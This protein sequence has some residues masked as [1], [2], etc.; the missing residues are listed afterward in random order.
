MAP[1]SALRLPLPEG[2]WAARQSASAQGSSSLHTPCQIGSPERSREPPGQDPARVGAGANEAGLP[3][4]PG[5]SPP[6]A[7][8]PRRGA[9]APQGPTRGFAPPG[10]GRYRAGPNQHAAVARAESYC[11][12]GPVT[13]AGI[14]PG[15]PTPV[16]LSHGW[17]DG[18]SL[19]PSPQSFLLPRLLSLHS[20]VWCSA[21]QS[22]WRPQV[23]AACLFLSEFSCEGSA[24]RLTPRQSCQIVPEQ[25]DSAAGTGPQGLLPQPG[26]PPPREAGPSQPGL[27]WAGIPVSY[28]GL[29]VPRAGRHAGGRPQPAR[30]R[31]WGGEREIDAEASAGPRA[32][33]GARPSGGSLPGA[34]PAAAESGAVKHGRRSLRTQPFPSGHTAVP[35]EPCGPTSL[36][37][38]VRGLA[39]GKGRAAGCGWRQWLSLRLFSLLLPGRA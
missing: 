34:S 10:P 16:Q 19:F 25:P 13:G 5:G 3:S 27:A 23:S 31:Y 8:A 36:P 7:T 11:A 30:T 38:D 29:L 21:G 1:P 24:G 33:G 37:R 4:S 6:A 26:H 18:I 15:N 12:A 20:S 35:P 39:E 14:D 17:R 28:S 2:A 9:S 22:Q 32:S